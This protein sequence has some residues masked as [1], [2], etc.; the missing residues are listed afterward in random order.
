MAG[1]IKAR[2]GG[3]GTE[4]HGPENDIKGPSGLVK[5]GI[6]SWLVRMG[7]EMVTWLNIP[8]NDWSR[9]PLKLPIPIPAFSSLSFAFI[10]YFIRDNMCCASFRRGLDGAGGVDTGRRS[11]HHGA[12]G[13]KGMLREGFRRGEDPLT[14]S[15]WEG[16]LERRARP[17]RAGLCSFARLSASVQVVDS[18]FR[19]TGRLQSPATG[20]TSW[21]VVAAA[22]TPRAVVLNLRLLVLWTPSSFCLPAFGSG[23]QELEGHDVMSRNGSR[24]GRCP[25]QK[26]IFVHHPVNKKY[27]V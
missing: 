12:Y 15:H 1:R 7:R 16:L 27:S 3:W 10:F 26:R 14:P 18:L 19:T 22:R 20:E 23:Q 13:Q 8:Y 4:P 2:A 24:R 11:K 5:A 6:C 25:L 21:K 9:C 17:H